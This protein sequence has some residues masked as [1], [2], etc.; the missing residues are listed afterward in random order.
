MPV[1]KLPPIRRGRPKGSVRLRGRSLH[2]AILC[3]NG[4]APGIAVKRAG[5]RVKPGALLRKPHVVQAIEVFQLLDPN[6]RQ[7]LDDSVAE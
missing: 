5:Y 2:F 1:P 6:K 4:T 7:M 3:A